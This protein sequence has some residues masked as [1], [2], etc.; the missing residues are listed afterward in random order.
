M[1]DVKAESDAGRNTGKVL[2]V[3]AASLLMSGCITVKAPDKPKK[4]SKLSF[5]SRKKNKD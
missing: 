4:K 1:I 2:C 5:L 3:V